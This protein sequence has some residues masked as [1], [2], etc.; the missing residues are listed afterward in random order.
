MGVS[1]TDSSYSYRRRNGDFPAAW[2]AMNPWAL[3]QSVNRN[4]GIQV[5]SRFTMSGDVYA[6][7]IVPSFTPTAWVCNQGNSFPLYQGNYASSVSSSI[8]HE[9]PYIICVTYDK[10]SNI[11]A[12]NVSTWRELGINA[13]TTSSE[14]FGYTSRVIIPDAMK[15]YI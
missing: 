9:A 3:K 13:D 1:I 8:C 7:Y 5:P 10:F 12:S 14:I 4:T 11:P 2:A 15:N 6:A